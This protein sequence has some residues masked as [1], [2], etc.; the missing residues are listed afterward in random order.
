MSNAV[1]SQESQTSRTYFLLLSQSVAIPITAVGKDRP[2][3]LEN[4]AGGG[5]SAIMSIHV[6]I[7]YCY[8]DENVTAFH[9]VI[10]KK[11]FRKITLYFM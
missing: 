9:A 4:T 3:R 1:R 10:A 8:V 2:G 11:S 7:S 5:G 6:S